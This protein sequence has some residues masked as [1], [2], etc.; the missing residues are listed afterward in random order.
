ML[1]GSD[2][3]C[4][5]LGNPGAWIES[6]RLELG[7]PGAWIE[8]GAWIRVIQA[9]GLGDCK[10]RGVIPGATELRFAHGLKRWKA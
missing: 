5:E 8:S 9:P 10:L 1:V 3:G 2:L 4:L 7:N 6:R